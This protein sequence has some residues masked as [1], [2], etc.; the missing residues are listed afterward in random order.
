MICTCS[1]NESGTASVPESFTLEN[2]LCWCCASTICE[3]VLELAWHQHGTA[4][5]MLV[6]IANLEVLVPCWCR[7]G[8]ATGGS[9]NAVL[10]DNYEGLHSLMH[11]GGANNS[12]DCMRI[13][14]PKPSV[15][16]LRGRS[17]RIRDNCNIVTW[18]IVTNV[19]LKRRHQKD[20]L[21]LLDTPRH[22]CQS[23]Q[24][25]CRCIV[26]TKELLDRLLRDISTVVW[27]S[28]DREKR[29][30]AWWRP[31]LESRSSGLVPHK[32]ERL[33]SGT[34]F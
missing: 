19:W 6:Y 10:Y 25:S 15:L 22:A 5:E 2:L 24:G 23:C 16:T 11:E 31:A 3:G 29:R 4:P 12:W 1:H 7:F 27:Q 14:E 32:N 28:Y 33:R 34:L 18:T 8:L 17:S 30:K 9:V 26:E 13:D 20:W 21:Q